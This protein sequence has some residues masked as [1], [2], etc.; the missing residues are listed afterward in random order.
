MPVTKQKQ[1]TYQDV[2]AAPKDMV[3]EVAAGDLYTHPRP[4]IPHANVAMAASGSLFQRF[5][6]G[7][8]GPGGWVFLVEPELHLGND[9]LVPDIAGWRQER[10]SD[11][12]DKPYLDI[13][14]NW[15]CEILSSGTA[16]LDRTIKLPI[17][18]REKV[19]HVWLIDPNQC[20][21]E[22]LRRQ[23]QRWLIVA[24]FA[25]DEKVQ[26]EPFDAVELDL[27]DWWLKGKS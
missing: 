26:A 2:L 1:A 21:L 11:L 17:Y 5:Q 27:S 24:T 22:V 12:P 8:G 15:L 19:E 9:V 25:E 18:A 4:A 13:A 16:R 6:R 10:L 7:D 23:D 20:T 14:P 3:A